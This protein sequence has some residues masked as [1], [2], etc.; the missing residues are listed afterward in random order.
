MLFW[1]NGQIF[2]LHYNTFSCSI[3]LHTN[4]SWTV[5]RI[6]YGSNSHSQNRLAVSEARLSILFYVLLCLQQYRS[7]V[8]HQSVVVQKTWHGGRNSKES[9][10]CRYFTPAP[11]SA[12]FWVLGLFVFLHVCSSF[13]VNLTVIKIFGMTEKYWQWCCLSQL[14]AS[15]V[16]IFTLLVSCPLH[17]GYVWLLHSYFH[18][19]HLMCP[20]KIG[21]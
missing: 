2:L 8:M 3:L 5:F 19:T 20:E 9:A 21:D 12:Y 16:F 11:P 17:S 7:A 15:K 14:N 10:G 4:D 1:K 6:R 13:W 18:T